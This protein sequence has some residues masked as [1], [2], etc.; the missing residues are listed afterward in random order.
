MTRKEFVEEFSGI[1]YVLR[2]H[3]YLRFSPTG[4]REYADKERAA[5]ESFA[6]LAGTLAG[7]ALAPPTGLEGVL[8]PTTPPTM[9]A[10]ARAAHAISGALKLAA[11]DAPDGRRGSLLRHAAA[12]DEARNR[13]R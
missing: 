8:D 4:A 2:E 5:L 12:W 1:V 7:V 3:A 6:R 10:A 11:R 9:A 13:M